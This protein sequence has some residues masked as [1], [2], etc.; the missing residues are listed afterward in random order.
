[1]STMNEASDDHNPPRSQCVPFTTPQTVFGVLNSNG[2][3]PVDYFA[4]LG[5]DF[6]WMSSTEL[7]LLHFRVS[8]DDVEG[9]K[10]IEFDPM[11][12]D[13][14]TDGNR[15][16]QVLHQ[17]WHMLPFSMSR[18]W[19]GSLRLRF[20]A[21]KPPRVTGKLLIRYNPDPMGLRFD[22]DKLRRGVKAEWDLGLTNEFTL[23][24][25]AYNPIKV[26]PT[27][28]PRISAGAD[29]T[30]ELNEV[31][32][33]CSWVPPIPTFHLGTVRVEVAQGLQPGNVFPDSIRVLVFHSFVD[34]EFYMQT[35]CKGWQAHCLVLS[36]KFYQIEQPA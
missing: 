15:L 16:Y 18:Y 35:D 12:K 19:S 14:E 31:F 4:K 26:R 25:P 20:L 22:G 3:L 29:M 7:Y 30:G 28:L 27:W 2:I 33:F 24:I 23:D 13:V 17:D 36:P 8:K 10:I 9:L 21:I 32:R 6:G 11:K 34:G 1:M 5:P